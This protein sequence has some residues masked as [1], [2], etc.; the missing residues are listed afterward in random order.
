MVVR[1]QV[2]L[3]ACLQNYFLP[4]SQAEAMLRECH[5]I[6]ANCMWLTWRVISSM[7]VK[8]RWGMHGGAGYTCARF[9]ALQSQHS[10]ICLRPLTQGILSAVSESPLG[11]V[12]L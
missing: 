8:L 7:P 12:K 3:G 5:N 11:T 9:K 2:A 6:L 1:Q 4:V 10:H